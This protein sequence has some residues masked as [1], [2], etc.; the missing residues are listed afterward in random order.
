MSDWISAMEASN[1]ARA[2]GRTDDRLGICLQTRLC[3]VF[4]IDIEDEALAN[5]VEILLRPLIS[6]LAGAPSD[7]VPLRFRENSSKFALIVRCD[8]V[9][10]KRVIELYG[11]NKIEFLGNGQQA[12]IAGTHP[13]GSRIKWEV[14]PTE[15]TYA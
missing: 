8:A 12:M 14:S 4:D 9:L 11:T 15:P 5:Q 1:L 7:R 3:K 6:D 2:A 10:S 13:S